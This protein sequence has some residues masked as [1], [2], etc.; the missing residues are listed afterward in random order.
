MRL[1]SVLRAFAA[2]VAIAVLSGCAGSARERVF[3]SDGPDV[4]SIWYG[5][6][7][8]D[9]LA[10]LQVGVN[11]GGAFGAAAWTRDAESELD[12]LFPTLDN[13]R[14][15]LYVFPHLSVDGHP[16]PGYLTHF[17]LYED[18]RIWALPGEAFREGAWR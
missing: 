1:Q 15:N 11:P 17:H 10:A 2:I 4:E 8:R 16:V 3:E 6:A 18:S 7:G 14:L 12:A 5:N 13:P 9:G